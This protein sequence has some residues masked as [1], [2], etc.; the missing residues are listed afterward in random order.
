MAYATPQDLVQRFGEQEIVRLT[1]PAGQELSGVGMEAAELALAN[2]S[3]LIDSYVRRRY[4]TPIDVPPDEI[5][6][7]CQDIAR[8]ELSTGDGKL[9]GEEVKDR[10]RAALAWLRDISEGRVVLELDEVAAGDESYAQAQTRNP[11]FGGGW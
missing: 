5:R 10:N 3:A 7:V 1:T 6:R 8:Y 11:V 9:P 2:A 4:R